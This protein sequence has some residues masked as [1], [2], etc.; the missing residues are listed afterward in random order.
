MSDYN[1][2]RLENLWEIP[3]IKKTM[4][5]YHIAIRHHTSHIGNTVCYAWI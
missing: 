1:L 2:K 4:P 5:E 3:M